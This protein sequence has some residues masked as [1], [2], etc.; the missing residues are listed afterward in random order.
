MKIVVLSVGWL[1]LRLL[2]RASCRFCNSRKNCCYFPRFLRF[3]LRFF[4][5]V[6]FFCW[7]S[8]W[9]FI[10]CTN[11]FLR[12]SI[13][14]FIFL[15]GVIFFVF[16]FF[17]KY[18]QKLRIITVRVRVCVFFFVFFLFLFLFVFLYNT[19]C[20]RGINFFSLKWEDRKIWKS[21]FGYETILLTDLKKKYPL[22]DT[23]RRLY[24]LI[25]C[26]C[27]NKNL[28]RFVVCW[29]FVVDSLTTLLLLSIFASMLCD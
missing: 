4:F 2:K 28:V 14:I 5:F 27:F 21:L 26:S 15:E 16:F 3:F 20:K 8:I 25:P 24:N 7:D 9:N 19:N 6:L 22:S 12:S 1:L 23:L 13:F 11:I 10:I 29:N 17:S 18:P